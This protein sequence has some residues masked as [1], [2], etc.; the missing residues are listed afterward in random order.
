MLS[1]WPVLAIIMSSV[2][3]AQNEMLCTRHIIVF[4]LGTVSYDVVWW[5][6]VSSPL[7][8]TLSLTRQHNRK[9][10]P[11]GRDI[12]IIIVDQCLVLTLMLHCMTKKNTFIWFYLIKCKIQ[13]SIR[14][15]KQKQKQKKYHS[16]RTVPKS[17][18]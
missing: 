3:Y 4:S 6:M 10:V 18:R 5:G 13:Q 15:E 1:T 8:R 11:S 2:F 12:N 17:N 7:A 14:N 9:T 16:A